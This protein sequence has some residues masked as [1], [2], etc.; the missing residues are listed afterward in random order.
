MELLIGRILPLFAITVFAL[1]VVYRIAKWN[2]APIPHNQ[3]IYP[4]PTTKGK[5]NFKIVKDLA[6]FSIIF[7]NDKGLWFGSYIFHVGLILA[8]AGHFVGIPFEGKQFVLIGMSEE[9][10]KNLSN[11][12]G[13]IA[14]VMML[15]GL[16]HLLVRRFSNKETRILSDPIDFFDLF[17]L[18]AIAITGNAMRF[19]D[20]IEYVEAKNFVIDIITWNTINLP[21]NTTFLIHFVLVM[22]LLMYFPFSKLMHVLGSF[23]TKAISTRAATGHYQTDA[24]RLNNVT[25]Q[26]VSKGV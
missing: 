7:K 10:S 11:I 14:G 23:Y 6:T 3:T 17:L 25:A 24:V 16:L 13:I 12:A 9:L 4:A 2:N 18:I 20:P 8:I 19:V 26:N 5:A 1:G 22:I 15:Y 21:S